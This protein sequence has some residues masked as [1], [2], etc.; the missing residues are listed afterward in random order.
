MGKK[1]K[2]AAKKAMKKSKKLK[3]KKK[4][5]SKCSDSDSSS[6]S[7]SSDSSDDEPV[8]YHPKPRQIHEI[9][10]EQKMPSPNYSVA[11]P[12]LRSH[13]KTQS[14]KEEWE[15]MQNRRR[16]FEEVT[17]STEITVAVGKIANAIT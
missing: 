14:N 1:K 11:K 5:K 17:T 12:Q 13:S 7:S 10:D 3:K 15:V 4:K 8:R 6:S 2:K 16:V 9:M